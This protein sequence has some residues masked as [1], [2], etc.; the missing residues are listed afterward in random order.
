MLESLKAYLKTLTWLKPSTEE[1]NNSLLI[2][3]LDKIN[4]F[5]LMENI[6]IDENNLQAECKDF[7]ENRFNYLNLPFENCWFELDKKLD[8]K[9]SPNI[10]KGIGVFE[11]NNTYQIYVIGGVNKNEGAEFNF[12]YNLEENK[13]NT[14]F[15]E[16]VWNLTKLR[17]RE[18]FFVIAGSYLV[19][20]KKI[21]EKINNRNIHYIQ[22]TE[23]INERGRLNG[24][25]IKFKYNPDHIIY[26]ASNKTVKT[27]ADIAKR[28]IKKPD[29]A[30]EVM[31]HWRRLFGKSNL[32]KNRQGEYC[33]I[34][35]TWVKDHV[36]GQGE[37]KKRTRLVVERV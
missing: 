20:I 33:V 34:G 35:R 13:V 26:V 23:K 15:K 6:D 31:G 1:L 16:Q 14:I 21:L 30:Y 10:L 32:G 22:N 37:L 8:F 5:Y 29:F 4:Y 12:S 36:R 7:F 25:F 11:N 3:K 2:H 17:I 9:M 27:N 18:E 19:M 24:V 28:I